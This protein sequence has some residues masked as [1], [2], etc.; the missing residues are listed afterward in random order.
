MPSIAWCDGE[1]VEWNTAKIS[2][3]DAGLQHGVGL[4]ETMLGVNGRVYRL[5]SHIERLRTS[6]KTLG[7]SLSL[8]HDPLAEAVR[9]VTHESDLPRARVRLTIT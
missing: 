2:V 8:R 4:F 6:A 7:L 5:D 3:F 9:R 1:F